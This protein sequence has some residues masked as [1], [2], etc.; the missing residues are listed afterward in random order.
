MM[1]RNLKGSD[2]RVNHWLGRSPVR[3]PHPQ[4]N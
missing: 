3:I 1:T 2:R 4:I